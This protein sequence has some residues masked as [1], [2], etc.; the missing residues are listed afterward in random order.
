M[1]MPL[2][3]QGQLLQEKKEIELSVRPARSISY[4]EDEQTEVPNLNTWPTVFKTPTKLGDS[5][6]LASL[7]T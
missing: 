6:C 2:R 4:P 5:F 7:R 1:S 3:S